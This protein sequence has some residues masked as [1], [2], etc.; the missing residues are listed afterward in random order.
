MNKVHDYNSL[1]K[2]ISDLIERDGLDTIE[3]YFELGKLIRN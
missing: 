2:D 3:R 1:V